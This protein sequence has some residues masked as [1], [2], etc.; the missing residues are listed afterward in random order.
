MA[1]TNADF[2][3]LRSVVLEQSSNMLDATRDYLFESRLRN[4]MK[5]SRC[6]SLE[7][8]VAAL[9][10][11]P[12]HALRQRIAEA[13][14][15]NE[16]SF[17]RDVAPFELMRRELFPALVQQRKEG[18]RLH[19]LSAA[20]STGQ[21]T[22]SLGMMLMESF[23]ELQHWRVEITGTDFSAKAIA[24]ARA[25]RYRQ[26][27]VNRGLPAHFQ[28][29][30]MRES[31]EQWEVVP[32]LKRLCRFYQRNLCN[33]PML[34]EKYDGIL[35]RNVL[36]YFPMEIRRRLLVNVHRILTPDGFLILG[37]SE[38]TGLPEYFEPVVTQDTCYYRPL[39]NPPR[40]Q[41]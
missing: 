26:L 23:S 8:L 10:A 7:R 14:T 28:T 1:C 5:E 20:C 18:R 29:K 36:L 25:G 39:P 16:T 41:H 11:Q 2:G 17:F 38:Q 24:R 13:M 9:R 32:E 21:E 34:L 27:E 6:S 35:L 40:S 15:V 4:L 19:F 3:F 22:Y 31:G 37:S 30:Y 12:E 33:E